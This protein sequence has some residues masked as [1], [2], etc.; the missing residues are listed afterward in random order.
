MNA[1]V[2][3]YPDN[4]KDHEDQ[5]NQ[6]SEMMK[7]W[8]FFATSF[9]DFRHERWSILLLSLTDLDIS[10]QMDLQIMKKMIQSLALEKLHRQ[11]TLNEYIALH[12]RN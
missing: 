6:F 8:R 11:K 10:K 1:Q 3:E 12:L 2:A 5:K 9:E 4:V 7:K